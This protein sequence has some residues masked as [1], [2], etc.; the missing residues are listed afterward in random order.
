[1][2]KYTLSLQNKSLWEFYNKNKHLDFEIMNIL[3]VDFIKKISQ[4][5]SS[6]MT[7]I[8]QNELLISIKDLRSEI[9]GIKE[10]I[11]NSFSTNFHNI[12]N[13]YIS[14]I[15]HIIKD[16]SNENNNNA[17]LQLNNMSKD[18]LNKITESSLNNDLYN[19]I[20]PLVK[21]LETNI[22]NDIKSGDNTTNEILM[23][24]IEQ[25]INNLQNVII[26]IIT[27]FSTDVNNNISQIKNNDINKNQTI[28]NINNFINKTTYNSANKGNYGEAKL[29]DVVVK[30][31]PK[32]NIINTSGQTGNGDIIM[33]RQDRP[34]ILFENKDYKTNVPKHEVNKFLNDVNNNDCSGIMLSNSSGIV[35]KSNFQIEINRRNILVYIHNAEYDEVLIKSAVDIIDNLYDK[36]Q[37]FE[38]DENTVQINNDLLE[39]IKNELIE[40][41]EDKNKHIKLLKETNKKLIESAQSLCLSQ[42]KLLIKQYYPTS[43][44]E[45]EFKCRYCDNTYENPKKR[46]AHERSHTNKNNTNIDDNSSIDE[47]EMGNISIEIKKPKQV[48][49]QKNQK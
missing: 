48:R 21:S 4:N 47:N 34:L 40:F 31:F 44:I 17:L 46:S 23:K 3:F 22:V 32:A 8:I 49:K 19:K 16:L 1:M 24:N 42:L 7:T 20:E 11:L 9:C 10:N 18:F 35:G 41:I 45:E 28:D 38:N 6:S 37:L 2:E 26:P 29:S 25:K 14:N 43:I 36:I 5:L 30:L 12:N 39:N 13:E 33:E 15:K 27:T